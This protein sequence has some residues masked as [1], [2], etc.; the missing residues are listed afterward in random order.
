MLLHDLTY[1]LARLLEGLDGAVNEHVAR[2]AARNAFVGDLQPVRLGHRL[3]HLQRVRI[4]ADEQ[5]QTVVRH[6]HHV[7]LVVARPDPDDLLN[8]VLALHRVQ[9][10]RLVNS[11]LLLY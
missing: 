8:H 11:L 3:D 5:A 7:R 1:H 9:L 6:G 4:L 10:V 2:A